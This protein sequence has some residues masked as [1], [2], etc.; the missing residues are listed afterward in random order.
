MYAL[1][2]VD[3]YSTENFFHMNGVRRQAVEIGYLVIFKDDETFI[4]RAGSDDRLDLHF[5]LYASRVN[6]GMPP[7]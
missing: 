6:T 2:K 7:V 1:Q 4:Q 5:I 3:T